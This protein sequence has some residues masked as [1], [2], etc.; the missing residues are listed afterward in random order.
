MRGIHLHIY[1]HIKSLIIPKGTLISELGNAQP[2]LLT[3][4]AQCTASEVRFSS[5]CSLTQKLIQA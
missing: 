2:R 5:I 3:Y 4:P 1:R